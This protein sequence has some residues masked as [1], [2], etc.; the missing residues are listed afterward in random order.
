MM[1]PQILFGSQGKWDHGPNFLRVLYG[2]VFRPLLLGHST[3]KC[4]THSSGTAC[5]HT[6]SIGLYT[7]MI[8]YM[9]LGI[10]IC[11]Y[12]CMYVCTCM[13]MYV[14][15]CTCMYMYVHVCACMY[16]YVHV[17][18]CMCMYVHVCACM[19]MYVHVCMYVCM[20]VYAY[21]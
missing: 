12:V 8:P 3:L 1:P 5:R 9:Y 7:Y 11:M 17:C 18:T 21:V 20:Y 19:C 4:R 2:D 6:S 15:V 16:M 14:H 13:F 10:C